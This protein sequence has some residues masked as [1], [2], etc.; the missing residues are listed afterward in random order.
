MVQNA[1]TFNLSPSRVKPYGIMNAAPSHPSRP[2][3]NVMNTFGG[4]DRK[5]GLTPAIGESIEI[6]R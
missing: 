3:Q 5:K 4:L 6:V 1:K 2:G